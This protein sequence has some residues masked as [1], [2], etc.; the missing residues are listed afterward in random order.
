MQ[1]CCVCV[2]QFPGTWF[3]PNI[4]VL[5]CA[6]N[7]CPEQGDVIQIK[8]SEYTEVIQKGD[9]TGSTTM[10]VDTVFEMNYSTGKW[11]K[12]KKY[13]PLTNVSQRRP[14]AWNCGP[15]T[16][17]CRWASVQ[18]SDISLDG[19]IVCHDWNPGWDINI[20]QW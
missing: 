18:Q 7:P 17:T 10:M 5:V 2:F 3:L 12:L 11:T 9:G 16:H 1:Q 14:Q 6:E 19:P 20:Y 4:N 13:K 8:L 15:K